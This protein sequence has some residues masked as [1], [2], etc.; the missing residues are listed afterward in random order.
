MVV[1]AGGVFELLSHWRRPCAVGSRL[2]VG[3]GVEAV[4]GGEDGAA[5]PAA[6]TAMTCWAPVPGV[7]SRLDQLP[8][9]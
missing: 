4:A 3:D 2:Q 9:R 8:L 1:V 6:V 7:R 5:A